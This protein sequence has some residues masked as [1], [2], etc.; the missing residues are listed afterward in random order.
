ML[1]K[2]MATLTLSSNKLE[3]SFSNT[4]ARVQPL[5]ILI[6]CVWTG[7][8][9]MVCFQSS[10]DESKVHTGLRI[11]QESPFVKQCPRLS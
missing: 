1:I 11:G 9:A 6:Q 5:E 2:T 4:D 7:A 8:Q 10:P 3:D